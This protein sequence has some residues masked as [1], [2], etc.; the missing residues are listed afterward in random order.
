MI[1]KKIK[2]LLGIILLLSVGL[3]LYKLGEIPAG[4]TNDEANIGYDAYSILR[5]GKDQ[6]GEPFPIVAF[7]GFGDYR[8]SFYTYLTTPSIAI[9]GLNQFAVRFPSAVLGVATVFLTFLLTK[10][11]FNDKIGLIASF[12]LAISPWHMAM[13]RIGIESNVAVFLVVLGVYFFYQ[14]LRKKEFLWLSFFTLT[15]SFYTYYSVRIFVPLLFLVLF[16]FERK[17]LLRIKKEVLVILLVCFLLSLPIL[18]SIITG[19]GQARFK[20]LIFIKE[21]GL[22]NK[23]NEKRGECL[24]T[25]SAFVCRLTYN[26]ITAFVPKFITNYLNHFSLSLL[27]IT[28][29]ASL[30]LMPPR[31]FLYLFEAPF[32]LIGLYL[33]A[34]KKQKATPLL[35]SWLLLAPVA[36]SLTGAEHVSRMLVF[37]PSF[38]I[39]SA[40]GLYETCLWIKRFRWDLAFQIAILTICLVVGG[41]LYI[42]MVDYFVY[43]PAPFSRFSHYGYQ[44]LFT[45]LDQVKNDYHKIYISSKYH[46]TKQYIFYLFFTQ[47]DPVAYQ[48]GENIARFEEENG[49]VRVAKVDNLFFVPTLP[50]GDNL[51]PNMLL[52]ADPKE[53][54]GDLKGEKIVFDLKKD[55]LFKIVKSDDLIDYLIK[56]K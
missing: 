8:L 56:H 53:L 47:Y 52:A 21:V 18:V 1:S 6:W 54:P 35:F 13:S 4:L 38:Q 31:G 3:R 16:Y 12:L 25:F 40:Y 15:F 45:Y 34:R 48:R 19:S 29:S 5:T 46:D 50:A 43:Y 28:G 17:K 32:L 2:F 55:S 20:H 44:E 33:L 36:D 7:K 23:I 22:L 51:L 49:W 37:L 27:F 39:L 30:S 14:G 11:L 9:F 10:Y 24:K 41:S 42:F 26:K